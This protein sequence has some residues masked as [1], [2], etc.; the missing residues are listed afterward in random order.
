M[1]HQVSRKGQL[2]GLMTAPGAQMSLSLH[3][4][5]GAL[6]MLVTLLSTVPL[7]T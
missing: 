1:N 5:Q 6:I 3:Y 2:E 4:M 7:I